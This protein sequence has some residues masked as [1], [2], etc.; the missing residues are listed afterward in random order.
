MEHMPIPQSAHLAL[1]APSARFEPYAPLWRRNLPASCAASVQ[2]Q[3]AHQR[4]A[5]LWTW[6]HIPPC[7]EVGLLLIV[8]GKKLTISGW[9]RT[10]SFH[11]SAFSPKKWPPTVSTW[12][13]TTLHTMVGGTGGGREMSM[14]HTKGWG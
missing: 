2:E 1:A 12:C 14:M 9:V 10:C 7:L 8:V 4:L 11:T 6:L 3:A 5:P 13:T